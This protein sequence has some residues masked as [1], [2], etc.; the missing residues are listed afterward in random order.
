MIKEETKEIIE[1]LSTSP[2]FLSALQSCIDHWKEAEQENNNVNFPQ[3]CFYMFCQG[4]LSCLDYKELRNKLK[5]FD[6]K[7][8]MP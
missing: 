2:E 8:Y 4:Y 5:P 1:C 3:L 7:P 6:L